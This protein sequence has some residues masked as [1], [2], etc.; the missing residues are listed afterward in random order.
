VIC[1]PVY[2]MLD[3]VKKLGDQ[4]ENYVLV[5]FINKAVVLIL[6][7]MLQIL[8]DCPCMY[9]LRQLMIA[10]VRLGR[11]LLEAKYTRANLV[12]YF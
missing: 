2:A 11:G 6:V 1:H 10:V 7:N 12:N 9:I 3:Q 8:S 4:L 5:S